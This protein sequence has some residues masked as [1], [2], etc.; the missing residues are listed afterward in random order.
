MIVGH[1]AAA[2]VPYAKLEGRPLWLL[3]V[4]ANVPEFLWLALALCGVEPTQPASLLD[5]T[6]SNLEVHMTYSHN[7]IPGIVQGVIVFAIVQAIW[8]DRALA[9]W[10]GALTIVHVLCDVFVGFKHELLG[11]HS[12]QISLD[13]Y[14]RMP[15]VAIAI[16][17][18][19]ALACIHYFL[20]SEAR[21]GRPLSNDRR[22]ALYA[23][24]VIGI[25]AWLS[26]T[27]MPLRELLQRTGF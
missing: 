6:F 2:L 3:L 23:V 18:A 20:R 1:Y 11:P 9:L 5:A 27:V 13:T 16:E 15:Q 19:F 26:A 4:C 22:A 12:P 17:L 21:H 10:C 7:L 14:G 8:R 25:L 24:F